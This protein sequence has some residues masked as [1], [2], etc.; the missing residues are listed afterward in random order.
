MRKSLLLLCLVACLSAF[1]AVEPVQPQTLSLQ[2][3]WNLVTL[4]GPIIV[5]SVQPLLKLKPF[6]LDT[7][8]QTLVRCTSTADLQ[9]G[10]G[11]WVFSPKVQTIVLVLDVTQSHWPTPSLMPGWNLIGF[12]DTSWISEASQVFQWNNG[13]FAE[14]AKNKLVI[15]TTYSVKK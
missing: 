4:E 2:R 6:R 9:P 11:L 13:S 7:A 8:S 12:L 14:I 15:G 5:E 1:A 3:G 10:V